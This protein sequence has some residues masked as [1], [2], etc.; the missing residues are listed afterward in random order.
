MIGELGNKRPVN[1]LR[2]FEEAIGE[3]ECFEVHE[4]HILVF[5]ETR[6]LWS[7]LLP[8]CASRLLDVV[9]AGD[10]VAI[11]RTSSDT[12]PIRVRRL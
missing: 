11:L 10:L 2:E 4:D 3:F 12:D 5:L 9:K 7:I 6:H 1:E 8:R